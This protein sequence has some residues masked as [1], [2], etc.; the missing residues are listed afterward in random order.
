MSSKLKNPKSDLNVWITQLEDLQVQINS[1]KPDSISEDDLIENVL[2]YL[3][4][5]H[6][7]EIHTLRKR[8][9]DQNNPLSIEDVREELN[10]KFEMMNRQFRTNSGGENEA[11]ALFAGGLKGKCNSCAKFG[12]CARD[13]RSKGTTSQHRSGN[14]TDTITS[15]DNSDEEIVCLYCKKKGHRIADCLKLKKK[16]EANIGLKGKTGSDDKESNVWLGMIDSI[17]DEYA[18]VNV[19]KRF[20]VLMTNHSNLFNVW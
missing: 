8:L 20:M 19:K 13:C 17:P 2:G 4:S 18:F 15:N 7:I 5:V 14:K 16:E 9:D 10:L 6:D 11:T 12:H 1:S 3:P